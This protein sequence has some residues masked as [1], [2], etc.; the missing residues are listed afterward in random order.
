MLQRNVDVVVLHLLEN[1]SQTGSIDPVLMN[2]I[3][4]RPGDFL[5]LVVPQVL[6]DGHPFE[7][8]RTMLVSD[9][10]MMAESGRAC[11]DVNVL[12]DS[13]NN[14]DDFVSYK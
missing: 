3:R 11:A 8:V 12:Y 13:D 9:G 2:I 6:R 14:E 4:K 7:Q 10:Y 1:S 5:S